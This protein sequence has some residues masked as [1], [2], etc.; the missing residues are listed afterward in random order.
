MKKGKY[1]FKLT[2]PCDL[3]CL[4]IVQSFVR[5]AA[6]H[7]G[8]TGGDV[9]RIELALEEG[10]V[11]VMEHGFQ[12]D[13]EESQTVDVVCERTPLGIRIVIKEKGI[14]FDPGRLVNLDH[15]QD[16]EHASTKGMGMLLMRESM[17]EVSFLNLGPEGKETHLVKYLPKE[18]IQALI[19]ARE[20]SRE[21]ES[22]PSSPPEQPPVVRKI[23]YSVRRML[24]EEA[25]E[26]SRSAY[27]NHGYT[28]FDDVIYYPERLVEMNKEEEMISAVAV[29]DDHE[30]MGHAALVYSDSDPG[31]QAKTAEFTF[32]F[33]NQEFRN[34]G[35]MGRLCRFLLTTPKERPLTGV[36]SYSVANHVFTQRGIMKLGFRDC[37]ILLGTSPAT[38]KFKGISEPNEQRI[39][40]VLSFHY[41]EPPTPRQIYAPPHHRDMLTRIYE[42]ILAPHVVTVPEGQKPVCDNHEAQIK[43]H[44]YP[45]E[46]CAVIWVKSY[47]TNV[48]REVRATLRELCIKQVAAIDLFLPLQDPLTY[49]L[50]EEL[51]KLGF[52]FAGIEPE[53]FIGEALILQYLNNI[54]LDYEKVQVYTDMARD[55]LAHIKKHDPYG[56]MGGRG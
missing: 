13:D 7:F 53:T 45:V 25:I 15:V 24:P 1:S 50:T 30:F 23:P 38:W 51:E 35:C 14:P 5:E 26:V 43:T 19:E 42:N 31:Y 48:V 32:V 28:F 54:D 4:G 44:V 3:S 29:S 6:M 2:V 22:E 21:A 27:K 8:F 11:N 40:V 33:V 10:V 12:E 34:Q 20:Q 36:Y 56:E 16:L 18:S 55:I 17:D 39:S 37:G 49:F 47:G 52:F 41:I 9:T 46:N